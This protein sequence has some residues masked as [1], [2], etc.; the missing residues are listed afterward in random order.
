MTD[1]VGKP[2]FQYEGALEQ[3]RCVRC[4]G[5]H[6]FWCGQ[7][8]VVGRYRGFAIPTREHLR[9]KVYLRADTPLIVAAHASC[10]QARGNSIYWIPFHEQEDNFPPLIQQTMAEKQARDALLRP[11][12]VIA[13]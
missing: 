5:L 4:R 8:F 12:A 7:P 10:N 6:C 1:A 2:W 9:E 11:S 3:Y 13:S